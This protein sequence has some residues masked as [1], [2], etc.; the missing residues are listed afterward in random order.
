MG[1]HVELDYGEHET[2]VVGAFLQQ[3]ENLFETEFSELRLSMRCSID[4]GERVGMRGY[5][6]GWRGNKF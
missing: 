3:W 4:D 1:E 6:G 5:A 2:N